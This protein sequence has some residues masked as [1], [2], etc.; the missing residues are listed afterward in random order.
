[1][2]DGQ[3]EPRLELRSDSWRAGKSRACCLGSHGGQCS[4]PPWYCASAKTESEHDMEGLHREAHGRNG[5]SRFFHRG[6][7]DLARLSDVL[8]AVLSAFGDSPCQPG[9][10]HA[11]P[12]RGMDGA[13]RPERRRRRLRIFEPSS[14]CAP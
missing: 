3:R 12:N 13:D 10:R 6:S 7:T 2:E 11:T 1:C 9:W 14:V 8:C 4:S 5:W